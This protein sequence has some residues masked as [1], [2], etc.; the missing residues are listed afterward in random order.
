MARFLQYTHCTDKNYERH[1]G[2]DKDTNTERSGTYRFGE[3]VPF[4]VMPSFS[5][6]VQGSAYEGGR[7]SGAGDIDLCGIH[8]GCDIPVAETVPG[9]G[10]G[11]AARERRP[12]REASHGLIR[13]YSRGGSHKETAHE[14]KDR[15]GGMGGILRQKGERPDIQTF[16]SS[17]DA[18]Y[19]RIRKRPRGKPSSQ[20]EDLKKE[21]L[22]ELVKLWEDG[23]IDLR[24]GDESHVCTSGY[25]PSGWHLKD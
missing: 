16:F 3:G 24:F 13:P 8:T 23:Y 1:Y 15:K 17:I 9:T 4:R 5:H 19:K 11:W 21:Q 18:R 12:W 7:F 2:K 20:L 22:Q 10:A 14:R 25:V 6:A